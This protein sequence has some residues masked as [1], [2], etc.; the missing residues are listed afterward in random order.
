[1]GARHLSW[2]RL[3]PICTFPF[4]ASAAL[5]CEGEGIGGNRAVPLSQGVRDHILLPGSRD[6]PA[7]AC[8][9]AKGTLLEGAQA[10][11]ISF[12][13]QTKPAC[14]KGEKSAQTGPGP[15]YSPLQ[16]SGRGPCSQQTPPAQLPWAPLQRLHVLPLLTTQRQSFPLLS[17]LSIDSIFYIYLKHRNV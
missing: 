8:W 3:G 10:V 4:A 15:G 9:G 5:S 6:H 7:E 14:G 1:M 13:P 12:R 16:H 17:Q 11:R 2:T